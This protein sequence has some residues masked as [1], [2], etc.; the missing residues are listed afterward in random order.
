[1]ARR[2]PH[3]LELDPKLVTHQALAALGIDDL[4]DVLGQ[5][6]LD[7]LESLGLVDRTPAQFRHGG[8]IVFVGH[9]ADL[10]PIAPVDDPCG[11]SQGVPR[12]ARVA[13]QEEAPRRVVALT[14]R[15]EEGVDR[16][17]GEQ[18]TGS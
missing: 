9:H 3:R 11:Q 18:P 15:R 4:W 12:P 14:R 5:D 7:H 2:V 8:A 10:A 13:V 1:M 17:E 6:T 16:R